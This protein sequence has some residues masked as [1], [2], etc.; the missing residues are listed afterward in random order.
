MTFKVKKMKKLILALIMYVMCGSSF[1]GQVGLPTERLEI[2]IVEG[3]HLVCVWDEAAGEW[4]GEHEIYDHSRS[5]RFDVPELGKWY[6]VGLWDETAGEY[7]YEKWIGH[8]P[9]E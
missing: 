3:S 9:T 4:L 7:V 1:S 8:F 5:I 6:W 2:P